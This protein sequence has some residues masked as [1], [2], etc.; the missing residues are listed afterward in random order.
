MLKKTILIEKPVEDVFKYYSFKPNLRL[1][2]PYVKQLY[3]VKDL[4]E[5]IS[6][7]Y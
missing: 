2:D 6:V 4:A 7:W 3:K 1:V 5:G